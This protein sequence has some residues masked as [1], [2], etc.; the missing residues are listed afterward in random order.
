MKPHK[1]LFN[2][3]ACTLVPRVDSTLTEFLG[4][5]YQLDFAI[6]YYGPGRAQ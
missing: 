2:L 5:L 1:M 4:F 6:T 3:L